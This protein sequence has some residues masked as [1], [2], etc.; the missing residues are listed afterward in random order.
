MRI[1]GTVL[2]RRLVTPAILLSVGCVSESREPTERG[3]NEQRSAVSVDD[4]PTAELSLARDR[5]VLLDSADALVRRDSSVGM[6]TVDASGRPRIRTVRAFRLENPQNDRER[7]T[8]YVLTRRST[9]KVEHL[10]SNSAVTLYFNED[11]RVSYATIMGRATVHL[12]P[13]VPRL[14]SF[15]DEGTVKFFWPAYPEDFVIIEI[16]PQWLEFI[17]PGLWNDPTTWRPQAVVF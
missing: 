13:K 4:V 15:L 9:R 6:V 3:A 8:V 14:Q 11:Q 16:V 17:G 7:F 2:L 5:A 1:G 12:D 10:A